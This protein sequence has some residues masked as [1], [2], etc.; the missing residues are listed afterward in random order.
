MKKLVVFAVIAA[1]GVA[2]W[3]W[4]RAPKV[5]VDV[6]DAKLVTDRLW[7]DHLPRN[8]REAVN[9]LALISDQSIGVF[10][11]SS[12]WRGQYELFGFE[13]SGGELR[14]VFPQTG[15]RDSVRV[16]ARSCNDSG[17][18]YCLELDG[19]SRGV[20]RYYSMKGWEIGRLDDEKAVL[21][22]IEAQAAR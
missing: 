9:G 17:F 20:K 6:Q 19:S 5:D 16:R 14:F 10:N 8:Q 1:A 18:D 15:D 12:R 4:Q 7:I 3:R 21:D 11:A 22:Q 2:A 13:R